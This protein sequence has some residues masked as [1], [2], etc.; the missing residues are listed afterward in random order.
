LT[1]LTH[2]IRQIKNALWLCVALGFLAIGCAPGGAAG[3]DIGDQW[4]NNYGGVTVYD[5]GSNSDALLQVH[6]AEGE[7]LC[8]RIVVSANY[9][10]DD[11]D[12]GSDVD[13]ERADER[14]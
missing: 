7:L 12:P 10:P 13:C 8:V 9:W 1:K 5:S 2:N 6:G 14:D 11:F 4:A 3:H